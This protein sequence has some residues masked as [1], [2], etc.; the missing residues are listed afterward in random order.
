MK[1]ALYAKL[2]LLFA[3]I[4]ISC[5]AEA[6]LEAKPAEINEQDVK[7]RMQEIMKAHVTYKRLTPIIAKRALEN[8]IDALDP[9]KTYF[10]QDEV[11]KWL[12]PDDAEIEKIIKDF[13][14]GHFP[15][16]QS[17]YETMKVAI[18]RRN[19]IEESLDTAVLPAHVTAKEFKDL[20]WCKTDK[21][22]Y[23][24]LSRLRALQ[25]EVAAKLGKDAKE[26]ALQR[27]KKRRQKVEDEF[28]SK[29]KKYDQEVLCTY[30]L[31]AM[32]ASLDAHTNYFTPQ[33][34][35][36]F[37]ISVQQRLLG[38]GV[39]LRDDVDG[40]TIIKIVEGGPADAVKELKA[41]D[42]IIAIN[43]EPVIGL[44]IIE[45]VDRIR[46]Q[47]GTPVT[48]RVVREVGVSEEKQQEL[49]DIVV[50][51]GEVVLK[52][53]RLES[54]PVPFADGA[55]AH[56]HL[57]SFYQDADTSSAE[58]MLKAFN[59]MKKNYKIKGVVL[60]LRFNGG[61]ILSQAVSVT[62]LFIKKGIVVSIKD[63]NAMVH[64]LRDLDSEPMW[65]GPL[66]VLINRGSAS[67]AE[68]VA[69]TLQD[70]G[71]ALI[72]GDDH[73]FGKG[74]FQTF[75]LTA[76]NP[77]SI[78]PKGEYKVTR[79][80]YYT[81]SGNTPQLAGVQ[82]D[83][84]VPGGLS[85]LDIGE[86]YAKYALENDSIEPGFEDSLSDVPLYQREKIR[87][88]YQKERQ[89]RETKYRKLIPELKVNSKVR[90]E[91]DKTVQGF[92]VDA[93][94]NELEFDEL[95]KY[96]RFPDFQL[97][98]TLNVMRDLVVLIGQEAAKET[99]VEAGNKKEI[100][101]KAA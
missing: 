10:L 77:N 91:E 75:T 89:L 45:V 28:C 5:L 41:K 94:N 9:M 11:E 100:E 50:S 83:I 57:H 44:D 43:G 35:N 55:L 66:I 73:S 27:L 30:I 90:Q 74:T 96:E 101:K 98:E 86:K 14:N 54:M 61:G 99:K 21:E 64:H 15:A 47:E 88:L 4:A 32:T 93:K 62:G 49:K 84:E 69:Q 1:D 56:I 53:T 31:K 81:V 85:F 95:G 72:V 70:Y 38:I 65:D 22:L 79:G 51:R 39:Q 63:E 40:F 80:C 68:I 48:L 36:Q 7:E 37:L 52:E 23:E 19:K 78:D 34:A 82:S 17:I 67:A 24:R 20:T 3:C 25:L 29:D 87:A 60:D 46:G 2:I 13:E 33:E 71:R 12:E 16:F 97:N 58:D 92:L 26:L 42:K 18:K 8:F 6:K 76:T 59:E